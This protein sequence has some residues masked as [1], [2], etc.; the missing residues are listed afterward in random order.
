[1]SRTLTQL[2]NI[3]HVAPDFLRVYA[4]MEEGE[5]KF[6]MKNGLNLVEMHKEINHD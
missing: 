3:M 5:D 4:N 1:M 2:R 6:R